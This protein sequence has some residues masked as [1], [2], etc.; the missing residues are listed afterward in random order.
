MA[1]YTVVDKRKKGNRNYYTVKDKK[2]NALGVYPTEV[3]KDE[4]KKGNIDNMA[5]KSDCLVF[6]EITNPFI[7]INSQGEKEFNKKYIEFF[8]SAV[9][10]KGCEYVDS[11][12]A[13]KLFNSVGSANLVGEYI[14]P[15]WNPYNGGDPGDSPE[16]EL[17]LDDGNL[18]IKVD[19]DNKKILEKAYRINGYKF[20][21]DEY[22]DTLDF[23]IDSI[24]DNRGPYYKETIDYVDTEAE[25]TAEGG[26]YGDC[27]S[28]GDG[29]CEVKVS[30][31]IENTF[32][33]FEYYMSVDEDKLY[34]KLYEE[35]EEERYNRGY[36]G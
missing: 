11:K 17:D 28:V 13:S 26:D 21:I 27:M 18:N 32:L 19:I 29:E 6:I 7:V 9:N 24:W 36:D 35:R 5:I 30:N 25:L 4:I 1:R 16:L 12:S 33:L 10:F 20:T 34:E 31:N 23:Y 14:A 22:E 15:S 2:T 8:N 3:V